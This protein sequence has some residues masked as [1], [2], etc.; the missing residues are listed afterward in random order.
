MTRSLSA[1]SV[2]PSDFLI[3]R[4]LGQ[5][6]GIPGSVHLAKY[7][8]TEDLFVV[9]KYSLEESDNDKDSENFEYMTV[10]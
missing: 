10:C 8:R 5:T 6:I 2:S 4:M 7:T 1:K 9:K 3:G